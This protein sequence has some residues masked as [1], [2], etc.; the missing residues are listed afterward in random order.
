M[1]ERNEE[2]VKSFCVEDHNFSGLAISFSCP[3][4]TLLSFSVFCACHFFSNFS[5][6]M[7]ILLSLHLSYTQPHLY[8][9]LKVF[10]VRKTNASTCYFTWPNNSVS[11]GLSAPISPKGELRLSQAHTV[12]NLRTS[13]WTDSKFHPLY[14]TSRASVE[15]LLLVSGH[16]H[17]WRENCF[18]CHC[19][20]SN[21]VPWE[22]GQWVKIVEM[23]TKL[24]CPLSLV[25]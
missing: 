16:E 19:S 23:V 5:D 18:F 1:K 2:R 3:P 11:L 8:R 6:L 20:L 15:V 13:T 10:L 9:Y 25:P 22:A 7:V 14:K 21:C 24:F 4:L 12:S 17:I